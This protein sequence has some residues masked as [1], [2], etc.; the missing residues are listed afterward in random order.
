MTAMNTSISTSPSRRITRR[1]AAAA[2]A[3][4]MTIS[5]GCGFVENIVK[6]QA[7]S[8][9][10]L[11]TTT[12]SGLWAD[13]PPVDGAK[14]VDA[15]IPLA[16]QVMMKAFIS[17]ANNKGISQGNSDVKLKSTE[18]VMYTSS[19]SPEDIARFYS[20]EMMQ[21]NGWTVADQPGCIGSDTMKATAEQAGGDNPLAGMGSLGGSFCAFAKQSADKKST[22]LLV[23]IFGKDEKSADTNMIYFRVEGE[24][25]K[26]A[27]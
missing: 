15:D 3:V 8:A 26:P 21:S 1:I 10:G 9:M 20:K 19:K 14:R 18:A 25:L 27:Q 4:L 5:M 16:A 7:S 6:K 13:V 11:D 23:M 17:A 24:D 2:L 22:T 12:A